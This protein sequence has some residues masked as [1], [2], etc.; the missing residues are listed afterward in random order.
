MLGQISSNLL[1]SLILKPSSSTTHQSNNE[2]TITITNTTHSSLNLSNISIGANYSHCGSNSCPLI[3][4]ESA[5]L[6]IEKPTLESV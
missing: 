1:N 5:E 2:T 3:L 6:A 4:A